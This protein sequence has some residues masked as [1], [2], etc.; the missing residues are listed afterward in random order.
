MLTDIIYTANNSRLKHISVAC[1]C[2]V[3]APSWTTSIKA[4]PAMPPRLPVIIHSKGCGNWWIGTTLAGKSVFHAFGTHAFQIHSHTQTYIWHFV[5]TYGNGHNYT[6]FSC[7]IF[8]AISPESI[9]SIASFSVH[10]H[11]QPD[12]SALYS[13]T[14][15]CTQ[16]LYLSLH[17]FLSLLLFYSVPTNTEEII[18][19]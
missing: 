16:E 9:E 4:M 12:S 15:L 2:S 6:R 1:L 10:P 13:I 19:F 18:S 17:L 7:M 14:P 5:C 11:R 8:G 3:C